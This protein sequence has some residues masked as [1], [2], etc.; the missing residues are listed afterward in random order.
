MVPNFMNEEKFNKSSL[1]KE[2]QRLRR[3]V[4]ELSILNDLAREIGASVNSEEIM[5]KVIHRSIRAVHAEQGMITLVEPQSG[6]SM[7]TLIRSMV[8]SSEHQAFHLDQ[9]L[10]GWMHLNKSPLVIHEPESD[11]RF[12]G[13]QW[14]KSI[15]SL[16]CVPLLIKS[17]LKGILTVYN[18]R[19]GGEFNEDDQKLLAIIAGQSAQ[20]VENARLYEKEQDLLRMQEELRL[21]RE[22]QMGLLPK[23]A[24]NIPGYDIA[25]KSLPAQL[26][27]GDYYDF[28]SPDENRLIVC[29]G[30]VSG[31]GLPAALLMA[32]LQATIRG[33]SLVNCSPKLCLDRSNRLLYHSTASNKFATFFYGILDFKKHQFCSANAGHDRPILFSKNKKPKILQDAGIALSFLE[34][35]SYS[36]TS[37][38]FTDN[39]ILLIYSDGIT[40]AMD[41]AENEFGEQNVFQT[42]SENMHLSA[43]E[44]IDKIMLNVKKHAASRPQ[45]DDMTMVVIKRLSS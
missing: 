4:E 15:Q 42:V 44:L 6:D 45:M 36:E 32:N 9:A 39:D 19:D 34:K 43:A 22:I 2:N 33:Q 17:E 40:E 27:G 20:V 8:S 29:L 24:P 1:L 7:Q 21:A 10:L 11:S 16:L 14:D 38:S 25:G 30:D 26:V 23:T 35:Y 12:K 31:K 13:I 28:I 5:K 18:K 3:A 37:I 41:A